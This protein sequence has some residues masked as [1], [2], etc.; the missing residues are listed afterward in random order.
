M[1]V[2]FNLF[3]KLLNR[4]KTFI[5]FCLVGAASSAIDLLVLYILDNLFQVTMVISITLAFGAG[6]AVNYVLHT[7]IT[8]SS[9]AST[10]NATKFI[11]VVVFNYLLTLAVIKIGVNF[12]GLDIF[13]S[14]IISLPI[15]AVSGFILSKYW[16]YK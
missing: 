5:I 11:F 12:S 15:V 4:S 16:V 13:F 1:N 10:T 3:S 8:F 7:K 14:K 6:L 9:E 2:T